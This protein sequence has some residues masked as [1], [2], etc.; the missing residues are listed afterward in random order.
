MPHYALTINQL[1]V[2][3]RKKDSGDRETTQEIFVILQVKIRSWAPKDV[4][5]KEGPE[6]QNQQNIWWKGSQVIL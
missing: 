6:K 2:L 3:L 1:R 5:R 4:V